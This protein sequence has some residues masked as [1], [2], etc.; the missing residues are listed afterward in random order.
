MT[1]QTTPMGPAILG[2]SEI[3][4]RSV[5]EDLVKAE[6]IKKWM[7]QVVHHDSP[8]RDKARAL[9]E[10][11]NRLRAEYYNFY[12]DKTWGDAATYHL[13]IDSSTLPMDDIADIVIGYVKK[14]LN[15]K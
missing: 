14:K 10:K 7:L 3:E 6:P 12:T 5:L 8:D 13:T 2:V 1:T 9:A 4:N 15:A 11:T